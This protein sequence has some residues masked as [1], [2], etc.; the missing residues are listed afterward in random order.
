MTNTFKVR[1]AAQVAAFFAEKEGG[2]INVLKLV[3]LIYLSDRRFME[4]YD[5]TILNDKFVS[6]DHGPVN[7]TTLDYIDGCQEDREN[8]E[9]FIT[10]RANHE[11]GLAKP[12]LSED[13]LDELSDVEI[14]VLNDIWAQFGKMDRFELRD[15][16][17]QNCPEWENPHGSSYPI[18][19]ERIFK[20]LNKKDSRALAAKMEAERDLD[21][22]LAFE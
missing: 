19:F 4:K 6:M 8:W 15:Y 12:D 20:F 14:N 18:P 17:H 22:I 2:S 9:K 13:D 3:K 21:L 11:V 5:C 1:K 10:D 7:S 16:T